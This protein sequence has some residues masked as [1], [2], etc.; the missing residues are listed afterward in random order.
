MV[1]K[2]RQM[3]IIEWFTSFHKSPHGFTLNLLRFWESLCF[4]SPLRNVCIVLF[5]NKVH[6]Q[7]YKNVS[8]ALAEYAMFCRKEIDRQCQSQ[9]GCVIAQCSQ[10]RGPDFTRFPEDRPLWHSS[11]VPA[12]GW[13]RNF[14]LDYVEL[15]WVYNFKP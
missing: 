12:S 7:Y 3:S 9:V 8:S 10:M 4:D 5:T 11:L 6:C 2:F 15:P 14:R 13:T 1:Y